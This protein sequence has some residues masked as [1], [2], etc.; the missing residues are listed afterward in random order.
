MDVV[1][2]GFG[3]ARRVHHYCRMVFGVQEGYTCTLACTLKNAEDRRMS[4]DR[5]VFGD[6][7]NTT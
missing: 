6:S 4:R 2:D 7:R 3:D 1:F 5:R